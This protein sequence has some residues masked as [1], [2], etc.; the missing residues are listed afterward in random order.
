MPLDQTDGVLVKPDFIIHK[1][2]IKNVLSV[3]SFQK[4]RSPEA[5]RPPTFT[6]SRVVITPEHGHSSRV[7]AGTILLSLASHDA[8][9]LLVVIHT[10][11]V[12][13]I[14]ALLVRHH[15]IL[16]PRCPV[17]SGHCRPP[18]LALLR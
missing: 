12:H 6:H 2:C 9:I 5:V 14:H 8:T 11:I 18:A 3:V 16:R 15:C 13:R 7:L 1:S 10:F 4:S 17:G